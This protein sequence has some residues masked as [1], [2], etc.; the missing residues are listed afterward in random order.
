MFCS[1]EPSQQ[2]HSSPV[3]DALQGSSVVSSVG[4]LPGAEVQLQRQQGV[5]GLQAGMENVKI[6]PPHP[7]QV[8]LQHHL[9]RV[10]P[11]KKN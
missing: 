10:T 4:L 6:S 1:S 3:M 8:V 2:A 5:S 7:L 9:Q 11:Q